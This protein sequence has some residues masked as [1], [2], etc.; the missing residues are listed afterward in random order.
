MGINKISEDIN[1][2]SKDINLH[3]SPLISIRINGRLLD[4]F[5]H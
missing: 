1:K 4:P 5:A 3:Y 2:K